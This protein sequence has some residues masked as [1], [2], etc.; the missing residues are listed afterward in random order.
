MM[1]YFIFNNINSLDMGIVVNKLPPI[2]K[3][4]KNIEKIE[5]IGRNGFLTQNY[6][7][8]KGTVRSIE[9]TLV[10][11]TK[12]DEV[13]AWLDGYGDL[14]V[15]NRPDRTYKATIINQIPLSQVIPQIHEFIIQFDC[16]PFGYSLND[17]P[18]MKITENNVIRNSKVIHPLNT[19]NYTG[20]NLIEPNKLATIN[21]N[22]FI[23][24]FNP[25]TVESTPVITIW[26]YGSID[27]NINDN[28]INLT[29]VANNITIDSEIM[30]CYRDGQL[31][32]NYMKGEFPIFKV[33][34]NKISWMGNVQRF[35][36]KPNWRWL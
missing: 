22:N 1:P 21:E 16:Q 4:E 7:T 24:I 20:G 34:I 15:S 6:G 27:L 12:I 2:V 26:G 30:D 9:C 11:G 17:S 10:E 23:E 33:G 8:Y 13:I 28:I 18:I 25:G 19:L 3:A 31:F 5:V 29:N 35:E 14:I 36:I 32:N